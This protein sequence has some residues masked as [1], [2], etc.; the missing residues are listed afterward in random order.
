MKAVVQRV[1]QASV[2]VDGQVIGSC[3][4]GFLVLLGVLPEDTKE[5]ADLMLQKIVKLRVFCDENGKMNL[6]VKDV[7]GELLIIS[8]FTL[9]AN[10][11]HGNRPDFFGAAAPAIA[12]P[13]YNYFT[14]RAA[15]EVRHVGHGQFGA[16]MQVSLINDGPVTIILDTD[17]WLAKE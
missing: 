13:L 3:G 17:I 5:T 7:D 15:E 12:E 14:E 1:S 9:M 10:C 6:S 8:Q 2:S 4:K 16:D 11:R